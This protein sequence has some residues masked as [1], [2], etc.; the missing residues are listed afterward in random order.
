MEVIGTQNNITINETNAIKGIALIFLLTHHLFFLGDM[1]VG[2]I[3]IGEVSLVQSIG[4]WCKVC[5]AIFFFF[6]VYG[7]GVS[8]KSIGGVIFCIFI[9]KGM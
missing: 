6:F 9:R 5:V 3:A 4:I 2:D 8:Q 7:L 1:P